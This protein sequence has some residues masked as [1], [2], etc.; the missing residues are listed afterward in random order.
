MK[1]EYK[2]NKNAIESFYFRLGFEHEFEKDNYYLEDAFNKINDLW[3]SNFDKIEKVKYLL[4][5]EAPLWGANESYIYNTEIRNSQFFYRSDLEVILNTQIKDKKEFIEICNQIGL[6]I[7]DISPFALN[8]S[9]TIINYSKN[10]SGSQ[11]LTK[12]QYRELVQMT[13]PTYFHKKIKMIKKKQS[14][15]IKVFFRY[16][17]VKNAFQDLI[18]DS[19]IKNMFINHQGDIGEISQLGGGVDREKLRFII[20]EF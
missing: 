20:D 11:K 1:L 6:L 8:T 19:L 10:K 18:K 16:L 4:I 13:L 17:R 14:S 12:K 15:K 9:D 7:L 3:K 5:A 2:N